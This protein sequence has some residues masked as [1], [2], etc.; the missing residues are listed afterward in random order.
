[1]ENV[2]RYSIRASLSQERMTCLEDDGKGVYHA[3]DESEKK[4]FPPSSGW[5]VF[6]PTSPTPANTWFVT[7]DIPAMSPGER[8]KNRKQNHSRHKSI[9]RR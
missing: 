7:T 8:A 6:A 5:Q 3:K 9:S 2:A 1:M 4:G